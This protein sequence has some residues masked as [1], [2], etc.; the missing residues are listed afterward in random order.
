MLYRPK[1]ITNKNDMN[2]KRH[3]LNSKFKLIYHFL[4]IFAFCVKAGAV[5]QFIFLWLINKLILV[6]IIFILKLL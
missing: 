6:A 2:I 3:E 5:V 1:T 4:H